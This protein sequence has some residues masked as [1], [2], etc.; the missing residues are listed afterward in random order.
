[1]IPDLVTPPPGAQGKEA[2]M[3]TGEAKPTFSAHYDEGVKVVFPSAM[4]FPIRVIATPA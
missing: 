1:M 3:R 4:G 2:V